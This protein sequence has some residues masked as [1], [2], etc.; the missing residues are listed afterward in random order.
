MDLMRNLVVLKNISSFK[1]Y[2]F[3]MYRNQIVYRYNRCFD[4]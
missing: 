3:S 2:Y 1:G 4:D